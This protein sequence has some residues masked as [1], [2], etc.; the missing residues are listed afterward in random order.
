MNQ[1]IQAWLVAILWLLSTAQLAWQ[2]WNGH[3]QFDTAAPGLALMVLL[4]LALSLWLPGARLPEA[5]A[6]GPARRGRFVLAALALFVV[7]LALRDLIGPPLL[8]GIPVVAL[9]VLVVLRRPLVGREALYAAAL[10]AVAAAAA[11]GV[12]S[13]KFPPAQWALLQIAL[14][15]S[16]LLAGWELLRR[17]ELAAQRLGRTLFLDSGWRPALRGLA[18]G[19]LVGIPWSLFNISL[20]GANND[21]WVQQWWQ[22]LAALQPGIAEEAWGRV[23]PIPLLFVI[24][25][26]WARPNAA[27]ATAVIVV[28]YWF[29]YLHTPGGL[30]MNSLVS[31]LLVGTVYTLPLSYIWLRR[32]LEPA[33]GFHI[34][35]D[36]ARWLFAY[37]LNTG[38]V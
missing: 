17:Q 26:R 6:V 28:G 30:S 12:G 13:A 15:P 19:A 20:G 24:L 25:R 29:A 5:G 21:A 3:R 38:L 33:I 7:L 1:R 34:W 27:L 31:T 36:F 11:L 22:P 35:Q 37:A 8:F 32:G 18:W 23:F 16:C 2:V 4:A 10:A 14:V 9:G